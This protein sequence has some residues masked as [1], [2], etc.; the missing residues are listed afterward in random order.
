MT[1]TDDAPDPSD[2]I[3]P[4]NEDVQQAFAEFERAYRDISDQVFG[5]DAAFSAHLPDRHIYAIAVTIPTEADSGGESM[6]VAEL[7]DCLPASAETEP[8]PSTYIAHLV[9]A[10]DDPLDG[11]AIIH[12]RT[13]QETHHRQSA[14]A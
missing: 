12:P 2:P 5:E 1:R 14:D 8:A 10:G 3:D 13:R 11:P 6:T 4:I 7:L 9:V